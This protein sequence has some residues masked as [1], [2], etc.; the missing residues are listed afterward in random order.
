M[1]KRTKYL[2]VSSV[3]LLL[4]YLTPLILNYSEVTANSVS[5]K[6]K[7][8]TKKVAVIPSS[9][10]KSVVKKVDKP[11]IKKVK[12][13]IAK[14]PDE[15]VVKNVNKP[16]AKMITD[17]NEVKSP[18]F[19]HRNNVNWSKQ[20]DSKIVYLTFD[21]GP[22]PYT[23]QILDILDQYQVKATFFMLAGNMINHSDSVKRIVSSGEGV[24]LHGVTHEKNKIYASPDSMA[25]EM[26][27]A[28]ATLLSL[29]GK[30]SHLIRPPYGSYPYMKENYVAAVKSLGYL[31]WDWNVDS[32]DSRKTY[33]APQ[34][35][36]TQT[37]TQASHWHQPV[38]LMHEKKCTV[39]ALP[40]TL[41]AIKDM[42][43]EFRIIDEN[44]IP[45]SF[46]A[47]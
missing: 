24:G 29:T 42:G 46:C 11:V 33:V 2:R 35:I 17:Q 6:T 23:A 36:F 26:K 45:Y 30:D 1:I 20:S 16:V 21:D 12:R 40:Q 9:K 15:L 47:Q 32:K 41:Q 3:I 13:P 39:E 5:V 28:E 8:Q 10:L 4:F 43:Y 34:T 19:I 7:D 27:Q 18:K 31:I 22:S 25:N 38:I 44:L 37:I 14:K